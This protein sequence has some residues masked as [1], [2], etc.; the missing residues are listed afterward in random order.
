[1]LI[2]NLPIQENTFETP[3]YINLEFIFGNKFE[4]SFV[5]LNTTMVALRL[6]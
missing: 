4:I 2:F 1:M 3:I 5:A 6:T